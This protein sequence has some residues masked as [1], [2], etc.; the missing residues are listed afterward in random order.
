MCICVVFLFFRLQTAGGSVCRKERKSVG[1]NEKNSLSS[2][3]CFNTLFTLSH[4]HTNT[5]PPATMGIKVSASPCRGSGGRGRGQVWGE[6]RGQRDR[7]HSIDRQIARGPPP[8]SAHGARASTHASLTHTRLHTPHPTHTLTGPVQAARRQRARVPQ[9]QQVRQ[10]LWA[11]GRYRR[12]HAHLPV[13]G[14]R[15]GRERERETLLTHPSPTPHPP[16]LTH[17]PT[18]H[19]TTRSWSVPATS[20]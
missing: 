18:T 9:G 16:A 7:A 5:L 20:S 19:T 15:E 6:A 17:H 3:V 14:E 4:T 10:L 13:P 11:Q 8:A 12:L 1:E 2:S